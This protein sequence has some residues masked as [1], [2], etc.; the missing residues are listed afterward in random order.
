MNRFQSLLPVATALLM[1]ACSPQ[2]ADTTS[3]MAETAIRLREQQ[4]SKSVKLVSW[5]WQRVKH[6]L[7]WNDACYVSDLY[8]V[9]QVSQEVKRKY[10]DLLSQDKMSIRL[11]KVTP[12]EEC[13]K[14]RS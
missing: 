12:I 6:Y 4:G 10:E 9:D 7:V 13:K 5:Y 8:P 14:L 2:E 1:A 11:A 3:Q